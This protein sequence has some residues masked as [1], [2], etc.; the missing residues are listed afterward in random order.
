M[1][2]A[3]LNT[4]KSA[5]VTKKR[6]RPPFYQS[7]DDMVRSDLLGTRLGKA[8]G[9]T[10]ILST[11]VNKSSSVK[12][13]SNPSPAASQSRDVVVTAAHSAPA[14]AITSPIQTPGPTIV[15]LDPPD[16]ASTLS[17]PSKVPATPKE[18]NCRLQHMKKKQ[19]TIQSTL[20]FRRSS[21]PSAEVITIDDSD[22]DP[23]PAAAPQNP[24]PAPS[25]PVALVEAAGEAAIIP[26]GEVRR[27]IFST[28]RPSSFTQRV[29]RIKERLSISETAKISG[30]ASMLTSERPQSGNDIIS[31]AKSLPKPAL[32]LP[33]IDTG[34][35]SKS[36]IGSVPESPLPATEAP[37]IERQTQQEVMDQLSV[38][39][40]G[41]LPAQSSP[42]PMPSIPAPVSSQRPTIF[43]NKGTENITEKVPESNDCSADIVMENSA[44]QEVADSPEKEARVDLSSLQFSALDQ[45]APSGAN[46]E[47]Q[48]SFE[49]GIDVENGERAA[50]VPNISDSAPTRETIEATPPQSHHTVNP[51]EFDRSMPGARG[52]VVREYMDLEDKYA[53]IFREQGDFSAS[54]SLC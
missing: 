3:S 12:H 25:T 38:E 10:S 34:I 26:T 36:A 39:H 49:G 50:E 4:T 31:A 30:S 29:S 52:R 18:S 44:T 32:K 5:Q 22:D 37:S 41:N 9:S 20:N 11:V 24:T 47:A 13:N 35:I 54:E 19:K 21:I 14:S 42:A 17:S 53:R 6:K 8:A 27:S 48:T 28:A 2:V 7:E 15:D 46:G 40:A 51:T 23:S 1:S 45:A 16:T 43:E 33:E